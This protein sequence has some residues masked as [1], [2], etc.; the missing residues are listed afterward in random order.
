MNFQSNGIFLCFL[1]LFA[2]IRRLSLLVI[3]QNLMILIV[4]ILHDLQKSHD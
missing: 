2:P 1:G 3:A 4:L